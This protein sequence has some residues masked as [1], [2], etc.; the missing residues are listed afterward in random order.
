MNRERIRTNL[1]DLY[2]LYR[3]RLER[4]MENILVFSYCVGYFH[5]VE[6]VLL[7]DNDLCREK[8][9]DIK[10]EYEEIECNNVVINFYESIQVTHEKLFDSF[11]YLKN[12][13][14]RLQ[15]EYA[16]FCEK[17]S[18]K[19]LDKYVYIPC[20]YRNGSGEECDDLVNNVVKS[21]KNKE[22]RLTILEAAAGYGKTCT[23]YEILNAF[24]ENDKYQ[25][26][27]SPA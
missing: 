16:K 24:L 26:N 15:W 22:A 2:K 13:Q 1:T 17:K 6:I 9:Q 27:N 3:F 12:S 4:D 20:R 7:E 5:N 19:L 23:A 21:A 18:E 8:A 25:A 14:K 10:R 11:F